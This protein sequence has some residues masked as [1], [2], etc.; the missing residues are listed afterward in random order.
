MLNPV[1]SYVTIVWKLT[2]I[3]GSYNHIQ[4]ILNCGV[5]SI[6]ELIVVQLYDIPKLIAIIFQVCTD[7]LIT[8]YS[9]YHA[10]SNIVS[11]IT[12]SITDH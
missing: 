3:S 12:M 2:T 4:S 9:Y 11:H 8:I 10:V 1:H 7:Y 5:I 6:V